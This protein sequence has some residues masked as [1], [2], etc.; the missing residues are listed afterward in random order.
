MKDESHENIDDEVDEDE[1]YKLYKM[2]LDEKEWHK[3]E[4]ESELKNING[5]K[6]HNGMNCIQGK[7]VNK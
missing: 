3:R 4:F 5:I 1:L 2:S 6:R 7:K